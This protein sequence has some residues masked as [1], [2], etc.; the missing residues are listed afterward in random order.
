MKIMD[1]DGSELPHR[2]MSCEASWL[3]DRPIHWLRRERRDGDSSPDAS[4]PHRFNR[5]CSMTYRLSVTV[6]LV[7]G[8]ERAFERSHS[9]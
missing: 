7:D 4:W 3:L 2:D 5:S 1:Q 9:R 8:R 6:M